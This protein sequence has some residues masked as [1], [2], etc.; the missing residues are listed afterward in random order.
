[1]VTEPSELAGAL[2]R[3]F[4]ASTPYLVNVITDVAAEYP[5]MTTGV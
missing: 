2:S 3:A 5:R 1:M 4:D